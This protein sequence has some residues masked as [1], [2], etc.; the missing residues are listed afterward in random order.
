MNFAKALVDFFGEGLTDPEK[1]IALE[2]IMYRGRKRVDLTVLQLI[3]Q[4]DTEN[5]QAFDRLKRAAM[6]DFEHLI[7]VKTKKIMEAEAKEKAERE[8]QEEQ[9]WMC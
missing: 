4:L 1:K 9:A 6:E 2:E 8:H 5:A 7:K 3:E